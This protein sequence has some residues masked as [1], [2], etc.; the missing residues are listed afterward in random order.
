[1][2]CI[3]LVPAP[4]CFLVLL[5][6][7]SAV[8]LQTLSGSNLSV[9]GPAAGLT[10]IV[11]VGIGK[12]PV[13]EAFLLSVVIAGVLQLIM[14]FVR[15]GFLGDYVLPALLKECFLPSALF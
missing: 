10:A 3:A 1:M 12:M 15:A 9:S 11:A 13:Y 6:V 4:R 2:S 5:R 7:S 8:L 14:G